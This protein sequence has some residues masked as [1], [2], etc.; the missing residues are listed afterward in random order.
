MSQGEP[1]NAFDRDTAV[2]KIAPGRYTANLAEDWQVG[3]GLNGG[4]LLATL[5]R[6][7]GSSIPGKPH[8][9]TVSAHYL[10]AAEA[11]AAEV[12]TRVVREGR[13]VA[14]LAADLS[15]ATGARLTALATL[16]DLAE[17]T[18]EVAT[19]AEELDLPPVDECFSSED[20]PPEVRAKAPLMERLDLRFDPATASWAVGRPSGRGVIQAWFRLPGREPDPLSLLTAVDVLPPVTFDLG[21][22]GWAPTLELTA[23]VRAV[24]EPGWLRLRQATRNVAGGLFEEDCEVWDS[25]GRLVAQSRQLARVPR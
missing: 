17:L 7:L 23:H 1:A 10:S 13:S 19:T 20:A 12:T 2:R 6:A 16:G 22:P 25:G 24:P 18:D 5:G 14:T 9:L 15:Q 3:G 21:R 8:V 4:Y 11:G